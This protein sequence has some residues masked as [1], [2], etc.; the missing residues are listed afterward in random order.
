MNNP[1][2]LTEKNI[3]LQL[4]KLKKWKFVNNEI[5]KL[6]EF[7][8]FIEAIGFVNKVALL[9][10]KWN[11][12]P[13]ITVRWNKVTISLSTHSKGGVTINDIAL[14]KEIEQLKK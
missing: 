12:H 9:A 10:E 1:K 6:Y 4:K 13:D 3:L 7:N 5:T 11:H 8:N 14:S 2:L